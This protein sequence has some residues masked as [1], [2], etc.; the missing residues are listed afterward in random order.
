MDSI[1]KF[2]ERVERIVDKSAKL[3][4]KEGAIGSDEKAL[5][6]TRN[7]TI[8]RVCE[9]MKIFSFNTAIARIME[10]VN[11]LY[12]YDNAKGDA[13]NTAFFKDCIKDLVLLLA[14]FVPH[15]AEEL[16]ERIG[17]TYSVFNMSYP[18]C[19][20]KAL[21]K[22]EYE[23]AVQVNSRMKAK[24]VVPSD[25]DNKTIENIALANEAVA[26]AVSGLQIVKVIVI[27]KRLVNIVCK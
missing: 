26:G 10:Y 1:T 13:K 5:N 14:P 23:L 22:D 6:Y 25:A 2:L 18:V 24:I 20:E 7:Y 12:K 11:D 8:K 9:D 16:N 27:P 15:I 19:D 4:A 21:V 3:E 17:G